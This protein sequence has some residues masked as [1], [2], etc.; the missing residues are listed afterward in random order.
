MPTHLA[1]RLLLT[2][3]AVLVLAG[4]AAHAVAFPSAARVIEGS[5]LPTFFAGAYKGLWLNDSINLWG[6]GLAYGFIAARPASS[7]RAIILLLALPPIA[8]A[9]SM[10]SILGNFWPA[11]LLVAAGAAGLLGGLLHQRVQ[12]T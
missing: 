12:R 5:D 7:S 3:A 9:I 10:Y 4:G 2:L 11:H 6:L 8:C 1:S